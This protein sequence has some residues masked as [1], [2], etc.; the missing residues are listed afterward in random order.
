MSKLV[1]WKFNFR[2]KPSSE[3]PFIR[4][5][6]NDWLYFRDLSVFTKFDKIYGEDEFD[7]QDHNVLILP[8]LQLPSIEDPE[9]FEVKDEFKKFIIVITY[10][11]EWFGNHDHFKAN[12]NFLYMYNSYGNEYGDI[13][14]NMFDYFYRGADDTDLNTIDDNFIL[15]NYIKWTSNKVVKNKFYKF[16]ILFGIIGP[17]K[18][19]A[20]NHFWQAFMDSHLSKKD[21]IVA[22]YIDFSDPNR[23]KLLEDNITD[24]NKI[25]LDGIEWGIHKKVQNSCINVVVETQGDVPAYTEK[26]LKPILHGMP[27]IWLA[28][29]NFLTVLND[30][31]Y[32]TYDF[33]DYSF[34]S[35]KCLEKRTEALLV[36]MDRLYQLDLNS[37][38]DNYQHIA[39]H[40]KKV[41]QSR[42]LEKEFRDELSKAIRIRETGS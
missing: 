26:T 24:P 30:L 42:D 39:E 21:D 29:E 35:I 17:H 3:G 10:L 4:D 22:S 5:T 2:G 33:I 18:R 14:L 40:N 23:T 25:Y 1:I 19:P 13:T 27:F 20:K 28:K 12:K 34:D 31:G 38:I 9:Y 6:T 32:K 15:Y 37:I 41:F 8:S 36:E 11:R 7:P 16:S